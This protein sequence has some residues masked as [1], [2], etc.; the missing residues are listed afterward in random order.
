ME[1][2]VKYCKFIFFIVVGFFIWVFIFFK[3]DVVDLI[4]WYMFV[5][6]VVIIIVCII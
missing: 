3:L 5:I 6:F 2:M 4:V 1:N